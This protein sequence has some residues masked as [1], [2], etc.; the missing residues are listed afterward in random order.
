MPG[1][2][3]EIAKK[4]KK[5]VEN[6]KILKVILAFPIILKTGKFATSET[7]MIR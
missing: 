5:S 2:N 3:P 6:L 4:I 1:E 7:T